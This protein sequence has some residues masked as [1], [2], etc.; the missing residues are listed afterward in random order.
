M[1]ICCDQELCW[2]PRATHAPDLVAVGMQ[3]PTC[4]LARE[5]HRGP[6]VSD[7]LTACKLQNAVKCMR[8][9][10]RF[11]SSPSTAEVASQALMIVGNAFEVGAAWGLGFAK[12]TLFENENIG[13]FTRP[14]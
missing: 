12:S 7:K 14:F 5:C 4:S 1:L 8:L 11:P 10:N 3:W 9:A 13:K 6:T 2:Q